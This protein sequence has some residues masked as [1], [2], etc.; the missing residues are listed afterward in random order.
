MACGRVNSAVGG[1]T[2]YGRLMSLWDDRPGRG[3]GRPLSGHPPTTGGHPRTTPDHRRATR[4][5]PTG[6]PRVRKAREVFHNQT[7]G[8]SFALL[9]GEAS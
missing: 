3:I 6:R 5:P 8:W 1:A 9:T 7:E 2:S 4:G